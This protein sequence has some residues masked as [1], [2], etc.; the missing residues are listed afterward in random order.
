MPLN[1]VAGTEFVLT[2]DGRW[3][4]L[5]S[6]IDAFRSATLVM[7]RAFWYPKIAVPTTK[8]ET[9]AVATSRALGESEAFDIQEGILVVLSRT[10]W[11]CAPSL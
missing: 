7:R 9:A 10:G 1:G 6:G 11:E 3:S 5:R 4:S 8:P 2:L